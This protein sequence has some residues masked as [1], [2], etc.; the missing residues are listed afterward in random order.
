M[1]PLIAVVIGLAVAFLAGLVS[2]RAGASSVVIAQDPIISITHLVAGAIAWRRRP[3][4]TT[5]ALLT[6]T[7]AQL[8]TQ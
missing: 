2:V 8:V 7:R 4:N 3:G 5:E 1:A 6:A